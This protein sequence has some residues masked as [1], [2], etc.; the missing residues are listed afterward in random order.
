M[1]GIYQRI[2]ARIERGAPILLDDLVTHLKAKPA[3]VLYGVPTTSVLAASEPGGLLH[4]PDCY[5]EKIIVGP[6]SKGVIDIDAP[7]KD[8]LKAIARR[9][10]PRID[11]AV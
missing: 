9:P 10:M 11:S 2:L 3:K 7:V 8:N 5:M 1:A 4:A 6:S